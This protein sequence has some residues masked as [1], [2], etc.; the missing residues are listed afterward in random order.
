MKRA[1]IIIAML[2]ISAWG[3]AQNAFGQ[4][5]DKPAAQNAPAAGVRPGRGPDK[6]QDRGPDKQRDRRRRRQE[7]VPHRP[8]RKMS[9]PRTRRL[10]P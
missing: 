3:L 6:Q 9:L 7:S 5:N 1:A 10:R 8:R 2:G 4:S